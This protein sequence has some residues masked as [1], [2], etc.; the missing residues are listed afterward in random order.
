M[1]ALLQR[2]VGGCREEVGGE[3]CSDPA[4]YVLWGKLLLAEALGP[5]CYKHARQYIPE[6]G[7]ASR[8][9]WALI[10][11]GDLALDILLDEDAGPAT[12]TVPSDVIR[13]AAQYTGE[14]ADS[15]IKDG[16]SARGGHIDIFAEH[17]QQEAEGEQV[18]WPAVVQEHAAREMKLQGLEPGA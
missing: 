5:R 11:L 3:R 15:L 4:E 9:G 13:L 6:S 14:L 8:S 1:L 2:H 18:G 17:L 16:E 10:R 7:L 12:H